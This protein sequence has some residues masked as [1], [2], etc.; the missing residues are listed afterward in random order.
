[1]GALPTRTGRKVSRSEVARLFSAYRAVATPP[2]ASGS[3]Y[4]TC[5]SSRHLRAARAPSR[6]DRRSRAGGLDRADTG[7][8]TIRAG[9][10]NRLRRV[11]GPEHHRRDQ[12]APTRRRAGQGPAPAAG[13]R[14]ACAH[15]GAPARGRAP[16]RPDCGRV[17]HGHR[18]DRGRAR[19][20][21]RRAPGRNPGGAARL[22]G[23]SRRRARRERD[24]H[25]PRT[26]ARGARRGP[27]TDHPH[28]FRRRGAERPDRGGDRHLDQAVAAAPHGHPHR[29]PG[30]RST[31]PPKPV[32]WKA[33]RPR[34]NIAPMAA[35]GSAASKP[36]QPGEA[37]DRPAEPKHERRTVGGCWS[38]CP[39]TCTASWRAVRTTSESA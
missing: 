25:R 31:V 16:P 14:N 5:L 2:P 10:R 6:R 20:R 12:A 13:A 37:R 32:V 18:G 33:T 19:E 3:S 29:A 27:A 7:D 22:R 35:H 15:L 30:E 23:S 8:R 38:G 24:A 4:S 28:A 36:D 34:P 39:R 17:V 21:A 26:G 9:A 11:R 1:M